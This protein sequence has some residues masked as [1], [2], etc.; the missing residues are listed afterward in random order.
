MLTGDHP[1]SYIRP[2]LTLFGSPRRRLATSQIQDQMGIVTPG[3][4]HAFPRRSGANVALTAREAIA[5]GFESTF[6]YRPRT[7]AQDE[8]ID[9]LVAYFAPVLSPS[10]G[11]AFDANQPFGALPTGQQAL[12]LLLPALSPKLIV[13]DEVFSGMDEQ[14]VGLSKRYLQE[15]LTPQQA[16]IFVSHWEDKVPWSGAEL[17]RLH[18]GD[19]CAGITR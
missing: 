3:I 15:E 6:S 14:M 8:E 9:Q 19:K 2:H 4:L 5:T 12:I 1:Q 17:R 16:A 13:L 10:D 18:L 11:S 7:N